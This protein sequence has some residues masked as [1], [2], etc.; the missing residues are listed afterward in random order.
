MDFRLVPRM[1]RSKRRNEGKND[2]IPVIATR[3]QRNHEVKLIETK[4]ESKTKEIVLTETK[5]KKK[6]SERE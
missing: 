4:P 3:S 6:T 2:E 5:S 1:Q